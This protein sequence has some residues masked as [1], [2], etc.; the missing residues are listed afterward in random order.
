[1]KKRRKII[2]NNSQ[3][4]RIRNNLRIIILNA[5]YDKLGTLKA[6]WYP[7]D[8]EIA[9]SLEGHKLYKKIQLLERAIDASICKC[10]IC[11]HS[12][13]DMIYI[14]HSKGWYCIKCES[15]NLIWQPKTTL[16]SNCG[17]LPFMC[18][19]CGALYCAKCHESIKEDIRKDLDEKIALGIPIKEFLENLDEEEINVIKDICDECGNILIHENQKSFFRFYS[20]NI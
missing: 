1:M 11:N 7:I 3:L 16:C 17:A 14:P 12:D 9:L 2:L 20:F 8:G 4:K 13:R 18:P 10:P 6:I 19:H 15:D 5:A